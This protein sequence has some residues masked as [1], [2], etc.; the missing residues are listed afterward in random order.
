M[1]FKSHYCAEKL[2]TAKIN[3]HQ[4]LV[5]TFRHAQ[6]LG[7]KAST[8]E[9]SELKIEGELENSKVFFPQSWH[10]IPFLTHEKSGIA[11]PADSLLLNPHNWY[12][13]RNTGSLHQNLPCCCTQGF[14][15][16]PIQLSCLCNPCLSARAF[17]RPP[18]ALLD[19]N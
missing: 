9:I 7:K 17:T 15:Y 5:C 19:L 8:T 6:L 3:R 1:R 13:D 11:S 14:L 12:T 18:Q 2:T 4:A 16:A 10:F